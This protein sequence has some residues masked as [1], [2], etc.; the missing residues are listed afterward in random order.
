MATTADYLTQLQAD[1]Q[2]LVNNLVAKGVEAT[3]DETFTSLV[4]KVADIQAGGGED[5]EITDASYLF[6]SNARN[7]IMDLLMS[8]IKQPTKAEYMFYQNKDMETIDVRNI[9]FS[10]C[11]TI[12]NFASLSSSN[13]T[14]K[15]IYLPNDFSSLTNMAHLTDYRWYIYDLD[16]SNM[17]VPNEVSCTYTFAQT[18]YVSSIKFPN[19]KVNYAQDMFRGSGFYKDETLTEYFDLDISSLDFSKCTYMNGMFREATTKSIIHDNFDLSM[20][21]NI[22]SMFSSNFKLENLCSLKNLGKAYTQKTANY[23]SYTLGLSNCTNLTYESLM[24]VINGLYDLNLTYDVANGG[25][26]YTQ[27]LQLGATN[28]AKLTEDEIAI[29]TAKGWTVS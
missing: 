5:F 2:T 21:N 1:K 25:T 7:N 9:D 28:L 27:K 12:S 13:K 24:N 20:V 4:P 29:A 10:K 26:L 8:K 14:L 23:S 6:Y 3:N 11:T 22:G 17:V 15:H 18:R 16:L 19:L